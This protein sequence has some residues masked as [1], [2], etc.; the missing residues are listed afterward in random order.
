MERRKKLVMDA[1]AAALKVRR[2]AGIKLWDP[3]CVYDLADRLE[4]EVRFVDIPSMEGMYCK[5]DLPT[6]LVSSLRPSG[7]QAFNCAHELGHHVFK[8]GSRI[9]KMVAQA[10]IQSQFDPEEFIVDCFAGF[11]L[12]PKSAVERAF[13][14]RGWDFHACTPLQIYIIAGWLGVGYTTL[15]HHLNNTLHLISYTSARDLVKT[16]PI[17]IRSACLG[18]DLS[19]DL[20]IVDEYW[21]DRA[22]DIQVGDLIQV[23]VGVLNEGESIC[24]HT[25]GEN[26]AFFIG[27]APGRARIYQPS[28]GWSAYVRVSRRGYIGRSI[29]RHLED[30]PD[31]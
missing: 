14:F 3:V 12:M 4:V 16:T 22:I 20:I 13:T 2:T 25:Q 26:S 18:K 10:D 7:R 1:M 30:I 23:P 24:L 28:T 6:I 8:H 27:M 17:K 29:F 5:N 31:D 19:E 9:D 15:I 11:L 21:S